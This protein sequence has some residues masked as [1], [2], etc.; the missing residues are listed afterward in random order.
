[1]DI[2][3][4]SFE[5]PEETLKETKNTQPAIVAMELAILEMLNEKRN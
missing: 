2:R 5:G 4:L 3:K 1:M